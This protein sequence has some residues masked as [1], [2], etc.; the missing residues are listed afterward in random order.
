MSLRRSD[1][2][3]PRREDESSKL[4]EFLSADDGKG[5]RESQSKRVLK[6]HMY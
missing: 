6:E 2:H 4:E 5:D 3:K 1:Q